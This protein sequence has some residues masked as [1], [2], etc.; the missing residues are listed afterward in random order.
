VPG[1]GPS[2]TSPC[3]DAA[4]RPASAGGLVRPRIDT[5]VL[6]VAIVVT[7]G[8][9]AP[10]EQPPDPWLHHGQDL[11]HVQRRQAWRRAKRGGAG[12]VAREHAV[13]DQRMDVDVEV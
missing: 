2:A 1:W 11:R 7:L 13:E 4:A 3:I 12:G 8:T 10:V 9:P 5:A 6:G